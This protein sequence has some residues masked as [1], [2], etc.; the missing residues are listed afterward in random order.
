MHIIRYFIWL[1]KVID[2]LLRWVEFVPVD[3]EPV[4]ELKTRKFA[5]DEINLVFSCQTDEKD[6]EAALAM[7]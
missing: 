5:H 4:E 6:F 2:N 1:W 3:S 7:W